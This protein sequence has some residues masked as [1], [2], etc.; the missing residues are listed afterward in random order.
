MSIE[1]LKQ[2]KKESKK[3]RF[4]RARL[5]SD[6]WRA[7][8]SRGK[9]GDSLFGAIEGGAW[10]SQRRMKMND[11]TLHESMKWREKSSDRWDQMRKMCV[12]VTVYDVTANHRVRRASSARITSNDKRSPSI[13]WW[14]GV[15]VLITCKERHSQRNTK[16]PKNTLLMDYTVNTRYSLVLE[17]IS[18][19]SLAAFVLIQQ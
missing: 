4:F 8:G 18:E 2:S 6:R 19:P 12:E 7:T 14:I 5:V 11:I 9:R 15:W 13:G 3:D 17:L 1:R 10:K 16:D